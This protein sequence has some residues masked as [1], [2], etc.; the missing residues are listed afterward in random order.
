[1]RA[2]MD[3][4]LD[5]ELCDRRFFLRRG[6]VALAAVVAL[7]WVWLSRGAQPV[8][9]IG[10]RLFST[11]A[12]LLFAA[13]LWIAPANFSVLLARE[14]AA[15][16]IEVLSSAPITP[17]ELVFGSYLARLIVT[18]LPLVC[19]LPFIALSLALGGVSRM[20]LFGVTVVLLAT[21]VLIGAGGLFAG[22]QVRDV[23]LAARRAF[24]FATAVLLLPG[25]VGD[26]L[27]GAGHVGVGVCVAHLS[28]LWLMRDLLD[29][30][31]ARI[32]ATHRAPMVFGSLATIGALLLLWGSERAVR[33][34][35]EPLRG[36]R[37][38][39]ALPRRLLERDP[40]TWLGMTRGS[41][42][43][44]N[45]MALLMLVLGLLAEIDFVTRIRQELRVNSEWF[46]HA[47]I[48]ASNTQMLHHA[49]VAGYFVLA[50]AVAI[51]AA[52]TALHREL[53]AATLDVFFATPITDRDI[54]RG[55][56][57][58]AT[59]APL[60]LLLLAAGHVLAA[61]ALGSYTV[62][63]GCLWLVGA[64]IALLQ[65]VACGLLA[66]VARGESAGTAVL[67]ALRG[68]FVPAADDRAMPRWNVLMPGICVIVL[69][70]DF[71]CGVIIAICARWPIVHGLLPL[72]C[73][74][75][76]APVRTAWLL[77]L[78]V[79]PIVGRARLREMCD[80]LIPRRLIQR[81]NQRYL[82]LRSVLA[83]SSAA[84]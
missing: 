39:L 47:P 63:G 18:G 83:E 64:P 16:A 54:V 45:P 12:W 38:R 52:G 25:V 44:W 21:L 33:A 7:L 73:I 30:G 19:G 10:A 48:S 27:R 59:M 61:M 5:H 82:P 28:P 26:L 51:A 2:V 57:I 79:L 66:A 11:T 75:V 36:R 29:F 60:P 31:S 4:D 1:M 49:F 69:F 22:A 42:R 80:V 70:A 17:L 76:G 41:R 6:M 37:R 65:V 35:A 13:V 84:R 15:G 72:L 50:L 68:Q 71:A 55:M 43:L 77:V 53:R 58:A 14:R 67:A 78:V 56:L 23:S 20:Q 81:R 3:R 34:P 9:V 46:W 8:D 40:A 62:T 32:A 74:S 24:G